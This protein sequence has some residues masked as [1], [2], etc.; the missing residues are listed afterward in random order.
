ME[1]FLINHFSASPEETENLGVCI[2]KKLEPGTVIALDGVMGSGKTCLARGIARGLGIAENITSP[3]FTIVNEYAVSANTAAKSNIGLFYHIDAWRL[4]SDEDFTNIGG[5]EIISGSGIT[6]I[7][8]SERISGA[9]PKNSVRIT[10]EITGGSSRK[11]SIS[12]AEFE[13]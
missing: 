10:I 11:I 7:E 2:G 8:W 4:Q 12:G 1:L 6:V 5:D 9:L 3:T 13:L